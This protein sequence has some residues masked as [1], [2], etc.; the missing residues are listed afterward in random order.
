VVLLREG[1]VQAFG[2]PDS[3]VV[4]DPAILIVAL[5]VGFGPGLFATLLSVGI[6]AYYLEPANS[7]KVSHAGDVAGLVLFGVVGV[8]IS[9]MGERFRH[10]TR[11][12]Q[13]FE[14]AVKCGRDDRCGGS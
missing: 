1:L 13:E 8:A 10:R 4:F 12:L 14:K 6:A 5:L 9:G 3:F 2:F 7:F 11:R